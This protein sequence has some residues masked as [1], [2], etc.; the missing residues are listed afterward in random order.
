MGHWRGP[1]V[2]GDVVD[3]EEVTSRG[4]KKQIQNLYRKLGVHNRREAGTVAL[5]AMIGAD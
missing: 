5:D 2:D 1:A 4:P 3:I